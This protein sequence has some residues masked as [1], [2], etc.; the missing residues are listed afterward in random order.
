MPLQT[1]QILQVFRPPKGRILKIC[2]IAK[3]AS[4]KRPLDS[5]LLEDDS[6][7][8]DKKNAMPTKEVELLAEELLQK[9]KVRYFK[10]FTE[11]IL[12]L[13]DGLQRIYEEFPFPR[14]FRGK[15]YEQGDIK[16]L[17]SMYREWAFQLHPSLAFT[18]ILNKCEALGSK[19]KTRITLQD[20][21]ERERD[22]YI[23]SN[24]KRCNN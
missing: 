9:K 15:G 12:T 4:N 14:N 18:D 6:E 19:G 5:I 17:M 16:Q 22:R 7:A 3:M 23:V 11:D 20:L 13:P 24:F 21:R 1:F 8:E 10:P 2:K